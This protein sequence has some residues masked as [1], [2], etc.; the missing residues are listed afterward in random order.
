M[1]AG[2]KR[3]PP[4]VPPSRCAGPLEKRRDGREGF[5]ALLEHAGK[6]IETVRHALAN[7]M[8]DRFAPG[9]AQLLREGTVVVDKRV[10]RAGGD[11]GG[12]I[13]AQV[14]WRRARVRVLPGLAVHEISAADEADEGSIIDD[15]KRGQ[16]LERLVL[17][18]EKVRDRGKQHRGVWQR[19]AFIARL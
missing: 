19:D 7:E 16:A 5:V 10:G 14:G 6:E 3:G 18:E 2:A 12:R 15:A 11:E 8:L 13:V 1:Q 17:F 4:P 9:R